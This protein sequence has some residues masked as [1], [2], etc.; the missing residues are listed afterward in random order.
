MKNKNKNKTMR[1]PLASR[2]HILAAKLSADIDRMVAKNPDAAPYIDKGRTRDVPVILV[3]NTSSVP[4]VEPD[5]IESCSALPPFEQFTVEFPNTDNDKQ[6]MYYMCH[7]ADRTMSVSIAVVYEDD[8]VVVL[9][10][11]ITLEATDDWRWIRSEKNTDP[12]KAEI[13]SSVN[14]DSIRD[15]LISLLLTISTNNVTLKHNAPAYTARDR[16]NAQRNKKAARPV[17]FY[18]V[19]LDRPA[20]SRDGA[21][22]RAV[23]HKRPVTHLRRAHIRRLASGETTFV[24]SSIINASEGDRATQLWTF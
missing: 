19:Q 13:L 20:R 24:S 15:W 5:T 21:A 3:K 22:T 12:D 8:E 18:T 2:Y 10:M 4:T 16:I 17:A 6:R 11:M 1:H 7:V 23:Q 14:P 9:P